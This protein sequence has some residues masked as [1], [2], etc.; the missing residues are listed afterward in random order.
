MEGR[1]FFPSIHSEE[2]M[3]LLRF[4]SWNREIAGRFNPYYNKEGVKKLEMTV[5]QEYLQSFTIAVVWKAE[6]TNVCKERD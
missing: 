1:I 4:C 5:R 2:V 6:V 3:I